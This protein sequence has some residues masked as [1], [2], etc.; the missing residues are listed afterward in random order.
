MSRGSYLGIIEET[1]PRAYW[2]ARSL[3]TI[4]PI[5]SVRAGHLGVRVSRLR[6]TV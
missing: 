5:Y 2:A 6:F 4:A 1:T 3:E